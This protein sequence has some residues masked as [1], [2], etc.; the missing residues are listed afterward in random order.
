MRHIIPFLFFG[1]AFGQS[2][3][4]NG[5]LE[6]ATPCD[7]IMPSGW[8]NLSARHLSSCDNWQVDEGREE[9]MGGSHIY[10]LTTYDRSLHD[11]REYLGVQLTT[12][13]HAGDVV[14]VGAGISK[15]EHCQYATNGFGFKFAQGTWA[16]AYPECHEDGADYAMTS[17]LPTDTSWVLMGGFYTMESD[18]DRVMIGNFFCD[19]STLW[20]KDAEKPYNRAVYF[21]DNVE[22]YL[23]SVGVDQPTQA[24]V[25]PIRETDALGR[26]YSGQGLK[27][28]TFEDGT[29]KKIWHFR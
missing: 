2:V 27:I 4:P 14:Y 5:N 28:T 12:T 21:V 24:N 19:E 15:A 7:T 26:P 1:L 3:V 25:K 6:G 17:I 18:A 16:T 10:A 20:I 13:L 9:P 23:V 29:S 22:V 11:Y 8:I